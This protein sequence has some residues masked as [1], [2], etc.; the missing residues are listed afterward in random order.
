[1]TLLKQGSGDSIG[2]KLR[3][4]S[5]NSPPVITGLRQ[6]ALGEMSK[7]LKVGDA[8]LSIND[9]DVYEGPVAFQIMI[10]A[11]GHAESQKAGVRRQGRW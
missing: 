11:Q 7:E 8:I 1:M 2:I 6:G 10:E 5:P 3:S 9:K 4:T